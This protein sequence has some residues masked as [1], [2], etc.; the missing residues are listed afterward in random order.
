[1]EGFHLVE[2]CSIFSH[3]CCSL[4]GMDSQ[5]PSE[6]SNGLTGKKSFSKPTK[7]WIHK[8]KQKNKRVKENELQNRLIVGPF[9]I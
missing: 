3:S 9:D 1:M 5:Y 2:L 4:D 8:T 7:T 6:T